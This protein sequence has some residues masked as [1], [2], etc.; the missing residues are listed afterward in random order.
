MGPLG[1]TG[2]VPCFTIWKG[3]LR[4]ESP[5]RALVSHLCFLKPK[6]FPLG[7]ERREGEKV[8][9]NYDIH[10]APQLSPGAPLCSFIAAC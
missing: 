10:T 4:D 7:S 3:Q 9:R 1:F 6:L 8:L 5:M 2:S